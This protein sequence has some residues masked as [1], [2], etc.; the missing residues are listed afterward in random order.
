MSS[1]SLS[2]VFHPSLS[3]SAGAQSALCQS[4]FHSLPNECQSGTAGSPTSLHFSSFLPITHSLTAT[5]IRPSLR[6]IL[7][8]PQS[9][10]PQHMLPF[11]VHHHA[12]DTL[13][14]LDDVW[15]VILTLR[16]RWIPLE[17]IVVY[18][19]EPISISAHFEHHYAILFLSTGIQKSRAY[20]GS[21][22]C[23]K[24]LFSVLSTIH[25]PLRSTLL[26]ASCSSFALFYVK[27]IQCTSF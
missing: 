16:S 14:I 20:P 12:L 26:I 27:L 8:I 24:W 19:V 5:Y 23:V 15:W 22:V 7:E 25:E 1:L 9:F 13:G 10:I 18:Y 4:V 3:L 21:T 6:N 2:A 17:L 11:N